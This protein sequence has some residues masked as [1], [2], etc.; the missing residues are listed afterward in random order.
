MS[1]HTPDVQDR[2]EILALVPD[3]LFSS[4]IASLAQQAGR[5][6]AIARSLAEFEQALATQRPAL[7]LVD[8]SARGIDVARA[9]RAAKTAN[10]PGV[11]AFGPH[12]DLAARALAMEAGAD[13]WVT[14]QRLAET[15]A[16]VLSSRPGAPPA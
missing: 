8:L 4:R 13:R 6:L 12:K 5:P 15:L 7:A 1:E 10:V 11:I 2:A 14:N 16:A 3:L 9:I